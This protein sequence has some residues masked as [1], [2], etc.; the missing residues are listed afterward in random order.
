MIRYCIV[1]ASLTRWGT[2]AS[3]QR[4]ISQPYQKQSTR[5][6]VQVKTRS[7]GQVRTGRGQL[8]AAS[9]PA[10]SN[11]ILFSLEMKTY[12]NLGGWLLADMWIMGLIEK[13]RTVARTVARLYT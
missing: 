10:N 9:P 1:P 6:P 3:M 2:I 5:C 13:H 8:K 11:I 7:E 12:S 4:V